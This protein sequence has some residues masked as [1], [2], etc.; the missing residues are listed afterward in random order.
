MSILSEDLE[1]NTFSITE[2]D[3]IKDN[4][5]PYRVRNSTYV[6]F[7][8]CIHLNNIIKGHVEIYKETHDKW[9]LDCYDYEHSARDKYASC[10]VT[11]MENLIGCVNQFKIFIEVNNFC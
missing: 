8:K 5:S 7:I 6:A 10:I 9:R 2:I 4:W 11:S 1:N 3:L